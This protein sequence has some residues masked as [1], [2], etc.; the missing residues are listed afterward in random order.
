MYSSSHSRP[1]SRASLV[2][3]TERIYATAYEALEADHNAS[4]ERY[5]AI[6]AVL[7]PRDERAWIGLAVT[8][9]RRGEWSMAA[10]RY[11]LGGALV[12]NST[13]CHFGRARAL[14]RPG[15]ANEAEQAFD[16]AES[17][18]DDEGLLQLIEA[19]RNA[20]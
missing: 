13:W 5:F 3:Q 8:R 11:L 16:E 1:F 18:T 10:A 2:A 6:L 9:E 14:C 4:A 20:S 7:S 12:P 15:H 17:T 19:E